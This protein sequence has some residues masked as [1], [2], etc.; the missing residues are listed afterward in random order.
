[1]S[2]IWYDIRD[3]KHIGEVRILAEQYAKDVKTYAE[4]AEVLPI[5]LIREFLPE[6]G[7][8]A[9]PISKRSRLGKRCRTYIANYLV[10]RWQM[11][12]RREILDD[13][14]QKLVDEVAQRCQAI[15]CP[16]TKPQAQA[17]FWIHMKGWHDHRPSIN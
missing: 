17:L 9:D 8:I 13:V 2:K 3:M 7:S 12:K 11:M 15:G 5:Y 14:C 16:S 6:G 1:M 4:A 10:R